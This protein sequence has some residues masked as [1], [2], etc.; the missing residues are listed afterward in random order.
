MNLLTIDTAT[1]V[2]LVAVSSKNEISDKTK[3]VG[4]SHS[5]TLFEN[6]D[7]ALNELNITIRDINIIGVGIGPGSFTGI[8]IAVCTARMLAQLLNAP[9][10]DIKTHLLYASSVEACLNENILIAFDAKK[11]RV[12]GALYK[13]GKEILSPLEVIPPGDYNIDF[14]I[15]QIDREEA[16]YIIGDGAEKYYSIIKKRIPDYKMLTGFKPRAKIASA[17]TEHI[18][19]KNPS[20]FTDINRVVPFYSRKSDAEIVKELKERGKG[21]I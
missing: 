16:T 15:D 7:C 21:I 13:K 18:Y 4:V 8:R 11:E 5:I 9:L 3:V 10:V 6:I 14:L 1:I 20:L 2:E 17:L 19:K 12:F